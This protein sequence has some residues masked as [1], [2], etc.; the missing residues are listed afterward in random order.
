MAEH[1][2]YPVEKLAQLLKDRRL[3]VISERTGISYT[4]LK[5]IVDGGADENFQTSTL[6]R[7]T[8]YLK[9]DHAPKLKT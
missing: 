7:V 2:F 8:D 5:K 4:T 1:E 3:T 6:Q 9:K